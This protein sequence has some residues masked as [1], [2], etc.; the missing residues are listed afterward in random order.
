[1]KGRNVP[2]EQ[3]ERED[4]SIQ[5]IGSN[6]SERRQLSSEAKHGKRKYSG[7]IYPKFKR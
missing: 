2:V 7:K 1:M 3:K 4:K 5:F 6:R